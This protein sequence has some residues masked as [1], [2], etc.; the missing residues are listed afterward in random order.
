MRFRKLLSEMIGTFL[1]VFF[2]CGTAIITQ[3][4][5]MN[6]G[7]YLST[8]FAFGISL[9][10][11]TMIFGKLSGANFNPV[12]SIAMCLNHEMGVIK[13]I[14][15]ILFQIIGALEAAYLLRMLVG[16]DN[17]EI[18]YAMN[19]LYDNDFIKTVIVEALLTTTFVLTI[20]RVYKEDTKV[21]ALFSGLALT[22]VHLLGIGMTGT[23]VNPARTLG[24]A[25]IYGS[26]ALKDVPAFII[27]PVCGALIA[28]IIYVLLVNPSK[29]KAKVKEKIIEESAEEEIQK[30]VRKGKKRKAKKETKPKKKVSTMKKLNDM[31][32]EAEDEEEP[33]EFESTDS[34]VKEEPTE[35]PEPELPEKEMDDD[36]GFELDDTPS[37]EENDD[38]GID[39]F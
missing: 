33:D 28:W 20:L 15:Y 14:E 11:L 17:S 12:V 8:A 9:M 23:S 24:I 4:S 2:G 19:S 22:L 30:P 13:C 31:L 34:E 38:N 29:N 7:G 39:F 32:F 27:G 5:Y 21:N 16:S 3:C 36:Y 26:D 10:I 1:L 25:I 37:D 18:F 35:S 6:I